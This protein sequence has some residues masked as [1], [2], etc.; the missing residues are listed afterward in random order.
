MALIA[1]IVIAGGAWWF[2]RSDVARLPETESRPSDDAVE[3][4]LVV[5]DTGDLVWAA[6][7]SSSWSESPQGHGMLMLETASSGGYD[8]CVHAYRVP[9]AA[10]ETYRFAATTY[11]TT[12]DGYA[13]WPWEVVDDA[14]RGDVTVEIASSVEA[15]PSVDGPMAIP[16]AVVPCEPE[17]AGLQASMDGW[18]E[19]WTVLGGDQCADTL[20]VALAEQGNGGDRAWWTFDRP[21][22]ADTAVLIWQ[23]TFPEGSEPEFTFSVSSPS[24]AVTATTP[25][26]FLA[27]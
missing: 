4:E 1:A 3:T 20:G 7:A 2:A 12:E 5:P 14:T 13:I 11:W 25:E 23:V 6:C 17:A 26:D 15:D 24:G 27:E 22:V 10:G 18:V 8:A 19:G 16:V 21:S 9:D